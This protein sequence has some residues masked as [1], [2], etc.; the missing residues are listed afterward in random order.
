MS[1]RELAEQTVRPGVPAGEPWPEL[2]WRDWEPTVSTLHMWTQIVGKVRLALAPPQN[3]WWHV[4]LYV[5]SRGLTTSAIP[6]ESREFQ[7]D[8]DLVDHRLEVRDSQNAGFALALVPMSVA[9][10]YRDFMDGLRDMGVDVRISTRPQEVV[11]A[12]PFELDEE[13]ASYDPRHA[14]LFW[15]GLLQAD[16]AA[17][18]FQTGFAGKASPVHFFWGRFDLAAT[19]YS[20]RP[21]PLHRG[22]VPNCADW[23]MQE[24]YSREAIS[25]GWWGRSDPPGPSFYAYTYPEP[26]GYRSAAV[27]PASAFFDQQYGEYVLPYDAVRGLPDPDAAVLDFFQTTYEAGAN[28]GGWDRRALEPARRPERPPRSPWTG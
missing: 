27:R 19:R 5:S 26:D 6:Y 18:I 21:A 16:R 8:L 9:H 22:G 17:K 13:H 14:N 1:V 20:G 12:I 15:R 4:T 24:A 10:F 28:L 2:P 3:H 23:V 7:I 25:V 11:Q